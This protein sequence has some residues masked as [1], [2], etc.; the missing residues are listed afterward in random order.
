MP[1]IDRQKHQPGKQ[2]YKAEQSAGKELKQVGVLDHAKQK[3]YEEKIEAVRKFI[4][5]PI[6]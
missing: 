3:E 6:W 1:K 5:Q 2:P 4:A